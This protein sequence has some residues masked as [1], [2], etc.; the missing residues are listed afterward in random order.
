MKYP[1]YGNVR[2]MK[3]ITEQIAVVEESRTI[4]RAI[5]QNYLNYVPEETLPALATGG[6]NSPISDRELL[7][8]A[9]TMGQMINEMRGEINDLRNAVSHLAASIPGGMVNNANLGSSEHLMSVAS[10]QRQFG[11]QSMANADP[12]Q[13][14]GA[15]P[16]MEIRRPQFSDNV[17]DRQ[18]PSDEEFQP[19]VIIDDEPLSL[20]ERE[21]FAIEKAL[22]RHHG[23]RRLAAEE[24]RISQRTL[25]RKLNEYGL[26]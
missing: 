17:I 10:N 2:E 13:F 25:Y 12:L 16:P 21:K 6:Q 22:K 1:W 15:Q 5:L 9:L 7:L 23:N 24:L 3:N 8:K 14:A 20:E 18:W 19:S 26:Q 4:T 11:E